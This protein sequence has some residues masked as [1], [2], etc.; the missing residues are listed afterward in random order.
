MKIMV[1]A[2]GGVCGMG[3]LHSSGFQRVPVVSRGT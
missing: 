1:I 2:E 3:Q